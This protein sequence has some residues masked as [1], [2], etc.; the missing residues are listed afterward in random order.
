MKNLLKASVVLFLFSTSI[1]VFQMSCTKEAKA[2]TSVSSDL[3]VFLKKGNDG[4]YQI[5]SSDATGNN[6]KFV[7]VSLPSGYTF[8]FGND[9]GQLKLSS[10]R[11]KIYFT[12]SAFG[13][14]TSIFSCSI[15]GT[16]VTKL[17]DGCSFNFDVK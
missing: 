6:Q 17:I 14:S 9:G 10:D 11:S 7:A 15:T 4:S 1:A 5:W 16:N 8:S 2:Q 13:S 3:I 12:A